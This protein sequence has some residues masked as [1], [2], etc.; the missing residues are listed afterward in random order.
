MATQIKS[1]DEMEQSVTVNMSKVPELAA[2]PSRKSANRSRNIEAL[3]AL[4]EWDNFTPEEI[5]EQKE[6]W[7][8]LKKAL[9]E[10]RLS[11]NRPHFPEDE[12]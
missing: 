12:G 4:G 6:T 5:Q 8:F 3:R 1:K 9:D 2:L 7:A 11:A 10:D